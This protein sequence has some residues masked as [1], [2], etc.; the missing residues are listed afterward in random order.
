MT[1]LKFTLAGNTLQFTHG[2]EYPSP[3]NDKIVQ[4]KDRT[5]AGTLK[6]ETLGVNIK[7]RSL[8]FEHMVADDYAALLHW[9][10]NICV[11]AM[12]SFQMTDEYGD[13]MTVVM[14]SEEIAFRET[15]LGTWAGTID[16]EGVT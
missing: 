10:Y 4:V 7:R 1:T 8:V 14:V 2:S 9:Y 16:L 11:G 6:V 15:Y 13:V 5:A 3:N 12:N